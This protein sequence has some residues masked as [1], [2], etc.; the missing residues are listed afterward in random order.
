MCFNL[1]KKIKS[2]N[3]EEKKL[4]CP[5]CNKYMDKLIKYEV[6][7]DVCPYCNGMWLDDNEIE[8]LIYLSRREKNER[9]EKRKK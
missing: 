5:R 2:E 4:K 6:I 8:K 3:K 1:F 9:K 7:I